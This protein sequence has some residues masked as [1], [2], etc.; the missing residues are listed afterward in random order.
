MAHFEYDAPDGSILK[1][2]VSAWGQHDIQ[3][4]LRTLKQKIT[5]QELLAIAYATFDAREKALMISK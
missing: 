4:E 5:V 1:A 3:V 2:D